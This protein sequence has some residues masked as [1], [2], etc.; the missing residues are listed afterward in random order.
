MSVV[1]NGQKLLDI[2]ISPH[3]NVQTAEYILEQAIGF[4]ETYSRKTLPQLVGSAG[5]KSVSMASNF[6]GVVNAVAQILYQ[7]K[8]FDTAG[9]ELAHQPIA[10]NKGMVDAIIALCEPL[11]DETVD[12]E[13]VFW[14][15]AII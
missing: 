2:L 5:S 8:S 6:A 1:V 10:L 13:D 7:T 11:K 14:G 4:V 3:I 9:A 15:H 12:E